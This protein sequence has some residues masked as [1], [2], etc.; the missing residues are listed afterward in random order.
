MNVFCLEVIFITFF[1]TKGVVVEG[2]GGS[3]TSVTTLEVGLKL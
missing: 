3:P 2:G 1:S